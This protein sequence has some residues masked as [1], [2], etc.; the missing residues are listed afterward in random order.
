MWGG[1]HG[2]DLIGAG[3]GDLGE[4]PGVPAPQVIGGKGTDIRRAEISGQLLGGEGGR[5]DGNGQ[6]GD[7]A[8]EWVRCGETGWI[9]GFHGR[10]C[11]R[12]SIQ[13]GRSGRWIYRGSHGISP[14]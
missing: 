8:L 13:L 6:A 12:R 3:D 5:R 10:D 7:P 2:W 14:L 11:V 4:A 9:G 1:L